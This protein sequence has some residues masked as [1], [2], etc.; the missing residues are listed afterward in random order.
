M[1]NSSSNFEFPDIRELWLRHKKKILL[2][3]LAAV[4]LGGI[5]L[6]FCP[7]QYQSEAQLF[8]RMGRESVGIDP[9]ATTGQTM[10]LYT[11]DREDEVK[12][13]EAVFKSRN[14]ASQVVDLIGAKV[15]LGRDDSGSGSKNFVASVVRW[16]VDF[17]IGMVRSLDPI[18]EREAAIIA[19]E[20]NLAIVGERQATVI[21]LIYKADSP[22]LA[23]KICQAVVDVGQQ[24][25]IRVHR[26]EE[27]SAFFLEQ[28]ERL[29]EQL[30]HSL[31][32]LR[33]AKDEMGLANIDQR[34]VTL[35]AQYNAVELDR[36]N[37]NQQLVTSEARI[38]DLQK[39]LDDVPERLIGSKRSV[40]NQGADML[41]NK[42]YELQMKSMD[43]SARYTESHPLVIAVK[44]QLDEAQHVLDE[45]TEQRTETS[46][47]V[48]PIH[49]ELSLEMKKETSTVAGLK[50]RLGELDEQK[51]AVLANIRTLNTNDF[52]LDQLSRE[53][54]L[55]RTKFSQYART[56]E[57][58][59][60]DKALQNEQISNISVSQPATL[61]EKPVSPS[62]VITAA[63]TFLLATFGTFA[64]VMYS[65][66]RSHPPQR[67]DTE[68]SMPRRIV[69]RR[70]RRE[71]ASKS[72]GHSESE[73]ARTPPK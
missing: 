28:Q 10:Q 7:R 22:Q 45:Q 12:S 70:V 26:N 31:V 43:L 32:E 51:M 17:L 61:A 39:Q 52:T 18:S 19:V 20:K 47:E 49:R 37:T 53:A 40:P 2:G 1:Q 55:A 9:T 41:R 16:P 66:R 59:R 62:R 54:D 57:E 34:R 30:D 4:L 46:D 73:E 58:A 15:V 21:S 27:S 48:N 69:R 5:F 23:Q 42:L 13:A 14:V 64:V 25:H 38:A 71:Y 29:R 33:K 3:P 8:I 44:E 24:E 60:I 67:I 68:Q 36:L 50:S 56:M 72:N 63:G 35:E 11:A 6:I 65:E